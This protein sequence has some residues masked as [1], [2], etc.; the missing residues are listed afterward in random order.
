M[1]RSEIIETTVTIDTKGIHKQI[2]GIYVHE[3]LKVEEQ[4]EQMELD[5]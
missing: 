2:A 4:G 3:L 5:L 1:E